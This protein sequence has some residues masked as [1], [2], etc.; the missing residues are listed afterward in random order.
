M[1]AGEMEEKGEEEQ[2]PD[3]TAQETAS[4][5]NASFEIQSGAMKKL[6]SPAGQRSDL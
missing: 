5:K 6:E 4:R 2:K 3:R 1:G